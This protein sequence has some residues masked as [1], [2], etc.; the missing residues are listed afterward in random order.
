MNE[1]KGWYSLIQYCPDLA[2]LEAAN[3]GVL[4]FCPEPH[5]IKAKTSVNNRRIIRFFKT[6]GHDW[7]R[8]NSFKDGLRERIES[9]GGQ[10]KTLEDLQAFIAKRAN[11]LQLT[12]PRPLKTADPE[13]ELESLFNDYVE[14]TVGREAKRSFRTLLAEKLSKPNVERKI[15]KD[16]KVRVPVLQREVEIPFGFQNGRF[17]LIT[18]AS[19][20]AAD[21][22]RS[23]LT[24]CKYAVE[25]RS[26]FENADSKYGELQLVV[27][28]K[29]R[30]KDAESVRRVRRVFDDNEVKLYRAS[31]IDLLVDVIE[32][33]GKDV[34]QSI[35]L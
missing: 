24:A 33:K 22:E 27:V 13:R 14:N 30:N 8:I 28:G 20:E 34:E 12:P 7:V 3:V 26:L 11:L 2:R 15:V 10:I 29:F 17:N 18:P 19:F 21:P 16:V 25:G 6:E 35:S 4:L 9:V 5:F 32:S 1:R 31:E 23:V